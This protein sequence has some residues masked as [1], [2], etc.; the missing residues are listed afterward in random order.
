MATNWMIRQL[1]N[2]DIEDL[3]KLNHKCFFGKE[4]YDRVEFTICHNDN[5]YNYVVDSGKNKN[6]GY[7][8]SYFNRGNRTL[9]EKFLEDNRQSKLLTL[10]SIGVNPEYRR[11]GIAVTLINNL[12]EKIKSD[13]MPSIFSCFY[14]NRL[15]NGILLE[16]RISNQQAIRIY[17][18]LGFIRQ[19]AILEN[20]YGDEDGYLY[21]LNLTDDTNYPTG[22]DNIPYSVGEFANW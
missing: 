11:K 18:K 9:P 22:S 20:Y 8:L 15:I 16:A 13:N 19:K 2:D 3:V 14:P 17:E 1:K 21:F 5:K 7:I 4:R 12:I 6:I 10:A